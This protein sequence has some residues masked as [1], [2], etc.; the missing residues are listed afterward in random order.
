M[1]HEFK[2]KYR[3]K[4]LFLQVSVSVSKNNVCNIHLYGKLGKKF[5]FFTNSRCMGTQKR[6]K[7]KY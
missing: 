4:Y 1:L 5:I 6:M 7:N 3:K 2:I